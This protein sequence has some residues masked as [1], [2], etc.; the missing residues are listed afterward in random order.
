MARN[1]V[2]PLCRSCSPTSW[3]VPVQR[4]APRSITA[5]VVASGNASSSRCSVRRMV[6]PSSRLIFPSVARKSLAAMGSSWLVGSSR[7]RTEGCMAIMEA[8]FKSC[9][10]PPE[11]SVTFL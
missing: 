6:V 5:T 3:G 2:C 4:S 9:F 11:S 10:C 7:M 1:M 8:R